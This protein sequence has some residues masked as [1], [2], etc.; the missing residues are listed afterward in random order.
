MKN[1][2]FFAAFFC[3]LNTFAQD[4][5]LKRDGLDIKAKV[6]EI[7]DQQVK[8]KD[9]DFQ[10]GPIRNINISDV[11]MIT[12]ENGQKEVFNHQPSAPTNQGRDYSAPPQSDLQKEF[13][14]IGSDDEEMLRYF[15]KNNFSNYYEDFQSACRMRNVGKGLLGAGI[16]LASGGFALMIAGFVVGDSDVSPWLII[17]GYS[18]MSAG[19]VLV[20]ASIPVSAVAG[21]RKRAIKNNFA[22]EQFGYYGVHQQPKLNFG[23]TTTGIGLT[24]NF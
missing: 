4:V 14:R 7:T 20:I 1:F 21:G 18:A 23:L 6:L 24:L 10:D 12:Y 5:I 11:F 19:E 15:K 22:R 9:Y 16:G 17:S 2:Y 8:Y 3:C 13:Y